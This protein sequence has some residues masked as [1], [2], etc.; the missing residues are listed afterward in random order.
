MKKKNAV[1]AMGGKQLCRQWTVTAG[2]A[3]TFKGLDPTA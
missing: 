2:R 1:F 3:K